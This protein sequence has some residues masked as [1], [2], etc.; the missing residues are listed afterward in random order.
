MIRQCPNC[1]A[2]NNLPSEGDPA[3]MGRPICA[4]CGAYLF[5][6]K[7]TEIDRNVVSK[8]KILNHP[9]ISNI[10]GYAKLYLIGVICGLLLSMI[11][12]VLLE[13]HG[14]EIDFYSGAKTWELIGALIASTVSSFFIAQETR[15]L[16]G[17]L[18][19]T[20]SDNEV[21][22]EYGSWL[23]ISIIITY[24]MTYLIA[25]ILFMFPPLSVFYPEFGTRMS[26]FIFGASNMSGAMF[27]LGFWILKRQKQNKL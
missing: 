16:N 5:E 4:R 15:K 12:M 3:K 26:S 14:V 8:A 2:K 13:A 24:L 6:E 11:V 22:I 18:D 17:K 27:V 19:K 25:P 9:I 23:I 21:L 1:G 10:F 20:T 7:F